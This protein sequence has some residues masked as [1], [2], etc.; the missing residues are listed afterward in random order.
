MNVPI[1]D[2]PDR[3]RESRDHARLVF[4]DGYEIDIIRCERCRCFRA[5]GYVCSGCEAMKYREA[6]ASIKAKM[7][8]LS[9]AL[10]DW[11]C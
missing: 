4:N 7:R 9:L 8:V 2:D 11:N 1:P 10:S 5:P 3:V 6:A